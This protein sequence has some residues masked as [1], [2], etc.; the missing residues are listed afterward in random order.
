MAAT[1]PGPAS[2]ACVAHLSASPV[3][4]AWHLSSEEAN[5][6][7]LSRGASSRQRER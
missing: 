4:Q 3:L 2:V 6:D 5:C 1:G 7:G